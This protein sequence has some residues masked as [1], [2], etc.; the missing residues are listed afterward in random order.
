MTAGTTTT[1]SGTAT[2]KAAT[3]TDNNNDDDH[4]T[5]K[6]N[7]FDDIYDFNNISNHDVNELIKLIYYKSLYSKSFILLLGEI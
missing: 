1:K 2:T 6:D 5:I 4:N 3:T 7:Y